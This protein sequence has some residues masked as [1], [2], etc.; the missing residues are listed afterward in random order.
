MTYDSLSDL[1]SITDAGRQHDPVQLQLRRQS[2]QH[3]LSRR[4]AAIVHLRS[5]WAISA[6][7]SSRTATRSATSTTPRDWS[8]QENFAD[9]T[10][11]TFAYDAHGNLLTAQTY[12]SG[13]TLTGTTTLTYNAANELTSISLSRTAC[14]STFTYNAAAAS[15]PRAWTRAATRSTTA[16]TPWAGSP[17]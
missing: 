1:T 4:H 10:N 11:Q 8:R 16:T 13:G 12:S 17:N 7:P 6:K 5:A 15:A 3:H 2:A 14:L 9:G